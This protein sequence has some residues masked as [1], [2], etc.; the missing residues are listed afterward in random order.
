MHF[1]SKS[2]AVLISAFVFALVL[3][4]SSGAQA[5]ETDRLT[6]FMVNQKFEVPGKVLEANTRYVIKLHDLYMNRN[7]VQVLTDDEQ[8]LLAQFLA[9]NDERR[10]PADK[11]TF[12]F[13]ET[14]SGYP[15]PI[16]SWFYPGRNIGLEFIYPKEQ[17]MEIAK[18]AKE[19]VLTTETAINL[20]DL[21]GVDVVAVE[22]I[23]GDF[24]TTALATNMPA[25]PAPA[26]E[27]PV[28]EEPVQEE[29]SHRRKWA[30][31]I[32]ATR[33]SNAR[34]RRSRK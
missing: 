22:P 34:N 8:T 19:P 29:D 14:Q 32:W 1:A 10:E 17:A 5:S 27:E 30:S 11:T 33:K 23:T 31:L 4:P 18:H 21:S 25:P 3:W 7:V 9:I 13:I 15:K 28:V 24:G 26:V 16:R 20:H 2:L 6:H 12:T